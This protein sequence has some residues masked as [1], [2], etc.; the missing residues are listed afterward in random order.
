[1]TKSINKAGRPTTLGPWEVR[2]NDPIVGGFRIV[3]NPNEDGNPQ[4]TCVQLVYRESNARLVA[5]A[6]DLLAALDLFIAAQYRDDDGYRDP[7]R[8]EKAA[9]AIAKA[10]GI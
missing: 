8:Y 9:N 2:K 5:A 1:M 6:P 7:L 10:R 4:T 3:G